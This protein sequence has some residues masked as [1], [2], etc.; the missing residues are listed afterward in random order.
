M[1]AK[2]LRSCGLSNMKKA[3]IMVFDIEATSLNASFGR[4]I[5][6]GYKYVGSRKVL[7]PT[8]YDYPANEGEPRDAGLCRFLHSLI[9]NEADIIVSWYGK[10]YDRKFINTRMLKAGLPPL[11]PLNKEH[12]DLFYTSRGN[13][14][15]HNNRLQGVSETLRCPYSKTPVRA[16]M[17]EDA[18]EGNPKAVGYVVAHC[19]LDVKILDWLYGRFKPYV[20]QH[21]QVTEDRE[22]C[23]ACGGK[24]I[25]NGT[26]VTLKKGRTQRWSCSGCGRWR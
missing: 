25:M 9:T 6:M 3:R 26:R 20:R 17:W 8:I 21:P 16:D 5:C 23:D 24:M 18:M 12:I 2:L 22:A 4:L 7:C 15:F 19:K 10:E 11:P 1:A 13:F 14:K